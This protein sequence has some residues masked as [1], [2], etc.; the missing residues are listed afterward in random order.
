MPRDIECLHDTILIDL[1]DTIIQER[2]LAP[3]RIE[4]QILSSF[5]NILEQY[6]LTIPFSMELDF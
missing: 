1:I 4:C 6:I 5:D 3:S 2:L